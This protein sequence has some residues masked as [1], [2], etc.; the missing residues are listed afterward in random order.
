MNLGISKKPLA[1][2]CHCPCSQNFV[3]IGCLIS[4]LW[5]KFPPPP[6]NP[7]FFFFILTVLHLICKHYPRLLQWLF[8][9]MH[10]II[11]DWEVFFILIFFRIFFLSLFSLSKWI[12]PSYETPS[13]ILF[14]RV[15]T[16]YPLNEIIK[17]KP[18]P[19]SWI[20]Q[21]SWLIFHSYFPL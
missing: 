1:I 12:I 14:L 10:S 19:L 2:G 21:Y 13:P 20:K 4:V 9:F 18:I 6:S 5:S 3:K 8:C 7:F 17:Q 15:I 11:I 16:V